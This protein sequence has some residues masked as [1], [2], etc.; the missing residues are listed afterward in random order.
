M[1]TTRQGRKG[2]E[3]KW[4]MTRKEARKGRENFRKPQERQP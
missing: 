2:R 3:G 1:Q 4:Q